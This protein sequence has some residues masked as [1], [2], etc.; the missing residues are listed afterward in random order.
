MLWN[1]L[2]SPPQA[3]TYGEVYPFVK[4]FCADVEREKLKLAPMKAAREIP[5]PST[6]QQESNRVIEVFFRH[7]RMFSIGGS[8]IGL[9]PVVSPVEPPLKACGN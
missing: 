8:T 5:K 1:E 3:K 4:L 2:L 9:S 7:P 6:K